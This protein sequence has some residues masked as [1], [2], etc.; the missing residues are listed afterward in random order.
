MNSGADHRVDHTYIDDF[1]QGALPAFDEKN[2]K[3]RIF[4]IASGKTHTFKKMARM[5]EEIIPVPTS[6][7]A[8]AY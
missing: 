4:N 3:S 5:V 1:L 7:R 8:L 2:L 6:P